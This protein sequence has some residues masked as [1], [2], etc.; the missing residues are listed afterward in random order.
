MLP[1][2]IS[3][4]ESPEDRELM[5]E[6]YEKYQL[7]LYSEARKHLEINEDV[8]DTVLEAVTR[9]IDKMDLFRE[10]MPQ[11]RVAYAVTTVKN[12]AYILLRRKN[13]YA[14][15]F[16]DTPADTAPT[17]EELAE[18]RAFYKCVRQI[19]NKLEPEERLIMEQKYI[20]KWTDAEMADGLGIQPQSVAMRLTRIKKKLRKELHKA[21]FDFSDWID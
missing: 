4:I 13:L 15:A 17:T 6:F 10:L 1:L 11:Q 21:G 8:E 20:L 18:K 3:A 19:W 16:V 7:L 12:L 14:D 9:M 2:I 5:T